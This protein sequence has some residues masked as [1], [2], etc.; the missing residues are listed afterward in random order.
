M[1]TQGL[2]LIWASSFPS[3]PQ[4]PAAVH[5][6]DGFHL[7]HLLCQGPVLSLGTG[8]GLRPM[9]D[10]GLAVRVAPRALSS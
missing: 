9:S 2:A 10:A 6:A 8:A 1:M 4:P 7:P 3:L 5:P